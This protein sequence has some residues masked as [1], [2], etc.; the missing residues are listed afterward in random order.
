MGCHTRRPGAPAARSPAAATRSTASAAC[1]TRAAGSA[2]RGSSGTVG[3]VISCARPHDEHSHICSG[4]ARI[5]TRRIGWREV[6]ARWLLTEVQHLVPGLP[7][8]GPA[9]MSPHGSLPL[10]WAGHVSNRQAH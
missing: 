9:R 3:S 6:V 1:A 4:Y 7:A 5:G 8:A 2:P 10:G